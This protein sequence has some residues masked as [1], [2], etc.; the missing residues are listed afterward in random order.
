[1]LD[2]GPPMPR[3]PGDGDDI[4][5]RAMLQQ[6]VMSKICQRNPRKTTLFIG[7]HGVGGMSRVMRATCLYFREDNGLAVH[8]DNV[9]FTEEVFGLSL[10]EVISAPT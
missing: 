8:G 10:N 9:D 6:V 2:I 3:R 7:C 4:E 5:S 1:M